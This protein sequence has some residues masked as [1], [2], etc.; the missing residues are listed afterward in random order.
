MK[1]K[2]KKVSLGPIKDFNAHKTLT[3]RGGKGMQASPIS[4]AKEFKTEL[5]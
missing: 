2:I 3:T 1:L 5:M 4:P